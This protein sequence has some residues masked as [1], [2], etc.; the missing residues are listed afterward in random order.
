MT[1]KR[2][3]SLEILRRG[4]GSTEETGA[5]SERLEKE[6]GKKWDVNQGPVLWVCC[7]HEKR[8]VETSG[9]RSVTMTARS[10]KHA[11]ET[12]SLGE[13]W[14]WIYSAVGQEVKQQTDTK[15][16]VGPIRGNEL[17]P[18]AMLWG[19]MWRC[20]CIIPALGSFPLSP[21][22]SCILNFPCPREDGPTSSLVPSE[23]PQ[24]QGRVR[25]HERV[26]QPRFFYSHERNA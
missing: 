3:S 4:K 8:T 26:E 23:W 13:G 1:I 14:A 15:A 21:P 18:S 10:V 17:L 5:I 9:D 22:P 6:L 25:S 11:Q 2:A 20:V 19:S 16:G 24:C 12:M 7:R